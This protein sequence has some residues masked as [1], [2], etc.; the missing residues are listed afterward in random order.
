VNTADAI[1]RLR[2]NPRQIKVKCPDNH[3]IATITLSVRDNQ[4]TMRVGWS[5]KEL[6]RRALQGKPALYADV[7]VED[8]RNIALE[9]AGSHC[10]Y[11]PTRNALLLALE[12]ADAALRGHAEHRLTW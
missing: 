1:D 10:R 11:N 6:R 5:G 7:A 8:D 4:L 9:C 3:F 2:E 12:L